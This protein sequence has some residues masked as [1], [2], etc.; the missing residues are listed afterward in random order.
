MPV[1]DD[2]ADALGTLASFGWRLAILTNCDDDLFAD[3]CGPA[4]GAI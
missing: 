1:F 2:A 3:D 4:S